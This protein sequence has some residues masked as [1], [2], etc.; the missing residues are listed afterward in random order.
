[1]FHQKLE[2]AIRRSKLRP[3]QY[4]D[5]RTKGTINNMYP[6]SLI[7]TF[8]Y[9]YLWTTPTSIKG[10]LVLKI[11]L[12]NIDLKLK[13]RYTI[14]GHHNYS[15]SSY[16]RL[17]LKYKSSQSTQ[18]HKYLWLPSNSTSLVNYKGGNNHF[19]YHPSLTSSVTSSHYNISSPFSLSKRSV[20]WPV[21]EKLLHPEGV[22]E[23]ILEYLRRQFDLF[24]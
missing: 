22:I 17:T 18:C 3:Q 4:D 23:G 15:L 7:R 14:Q 21:R 8:F 9:G 2:K 20:Q 6:I 12:V 24:W 13:S 16:R 1:M 11:S 10:S 19:Q 5:A